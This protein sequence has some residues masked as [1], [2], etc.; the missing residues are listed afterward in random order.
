MKKLLTFIFISTLL[1]DAF[2]QKTEDLSQYFKE[3]DLEGGFFLY[4]YQKKE[5]IVSD[6]ADFTKPTSP[7]STFKIPNSLIALETGA[8]KDENEVIKW[9]GQK[10]WLEA[11]NADHDLK[12]AFKNSTVWF[13]QELA[14]RIGEKNYHQF[15]QAL[16]YGNQDI[17]A[18]L[19]T[20]WLGSSLTISP[21]N[22]LEF[23]V[24]LYEEKLPFSKRTL[25]IVKK[26]MIRKETP[27]YTI[28]AK[29][30]WADTPPK[31]IGW[32]VGYV[33]KKDNVYFFAT[34]VY[35][36]V[37]KSIPTFGGDRIEITTKILEKLGII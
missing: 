37:E 33:Q 25:E 22:Q 29:T 26:I 30:G 28:R 21:K 20:F 18:G 23:L 11:W 14:R 8:I 34:R 1:G 6:K 3:K 19:T 4:D 35:K 13:Y 31:D 17:S 12:N 7:A 24:K 2:A 16:S 15:L 27:E 10:R 9:D 36:P 32:Y 5:Y